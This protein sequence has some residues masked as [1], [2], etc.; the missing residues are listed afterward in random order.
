MRE[1]WALLRASWLTESSYRLNMVFSIASLAFVVLPLYFVTK[2][3]Q[4]I[5]E[6]T[7]ASQSRQYF[8]FALLGAATYT[9]VA[10]VLTALPG[11]LASAI[12]RG[13]LETYLATPTPAGLLFLGMSGY[14]VCWAVL[15]GAILTTVG[16]FLGVRL[17]WGSA[18]A[19]L[20]II[21]LLIVAYGALGAM[22][23][24]L[25][26]CFR[27]T[28]PFVTGVLT[29]SMLLGGVYYPTN[30]I[31]SWLQD[32][33]KALPLSYGLRAL[34]QTALLGEPF[35]AVGHDVAV[36]ASFTA[37][38]FATGT[39]ALVGALRYARKAGTLSMY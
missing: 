1:C 18:P 26:V 38:L 4:P 6:S 14:S 19:I 30:V 11:A 29:G 7:I 15:R 32:L 31:P 34:R 33:S 36:L 27:T 3:L 21:G 16:A 22:A 25:V 12:S 10:A 37:I 28:G 2:A 23:A 35:A 20:L 5:M 9:L 39:L 8:A 24:A 17:A 13:T